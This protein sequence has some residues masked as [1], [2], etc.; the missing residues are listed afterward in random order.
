MSMSRIL[1]LTLAAAILCGC[2][3]SSLPPISYDFQGIHIGDPVSSLE[4][5]GFEGKTLSGSALGAYSKG[6]D[7]GEYQM[8][9]L[10]YTLDGK[11]ES[12][13]FYTNRSI[14]PPLFI[15][16]TEEKYGQPHREEL[17]SG[18]RTRVWDTTDGEFSI[19]VKEGSLSSTKFKDYESA[20]D[21]EITKN[22]LDKI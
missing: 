9:V 1:G 16:A 10:A 19:G 5:A 17:R 12:L 15:S 4:A 7:F 20:M 14:L 2:N 18:E 3:K 13:V 11:V 6:V 21:D 8:G 22:A